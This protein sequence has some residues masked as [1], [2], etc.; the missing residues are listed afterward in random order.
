[1]NPIFAVLS[2]KL[3]VRSFVSERVGGA[4]LIPLLWSGAADDI[5]FDQL[6]P[7][8][9]FKSNHASGQFI[10]VEAGDKVRPDE[11][12]AAGRNWLAQPFGIVQDEPGYVPVVPK[13]MIERTVTTDAGERPNE[14]RFFMF[15]GKAAVINTVFVESGLI[16]NGAF[17][18]PDWRRLDWHFSRLVDREFPPPKRLSDMLSI[19]ERLAK[20]L[21]HVRV[22]FYD[23]GDH[24]YIG[25]MTLYSWSGMSPFSP[26]QADFALGAH[27]RIRFRLLRAAC[28][29]LFSRRG[30][31]GPAT[32]TAGKST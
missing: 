2:D 5:P 13:L 1:M 18:T 27:W 6:Q 22:D 23:C 15:D 12:R 20:G 8:Y 21:D 3:A 14:I 25:E 24:I 29:V 9:V 4:V 26:D 32:S 10:L 16:R 30:I 19:A 28:A 17:H 31:K 11:F 7:P